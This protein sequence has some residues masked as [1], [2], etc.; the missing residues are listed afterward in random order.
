MG[1]ETFKSPKA[2]K[3]Q[4]RSVVGFLKKSITK[5]FGKTADDKELDAISAFV[6]NAMGKD[7]KE[8]VFQMSAILEA[9]TKGGIIV[10]D[11]FNTSQAHVM[12]LFNA[13]LD[14][15]R[16]IEVTGLGKV[17]AHP[18]FLAIGT[19]NK[20]YQ[21]TFDSN[22]ATV[23]R[24]EPLIFPPLESISKLLE[25]KIPELGYETINI[26]NKLYAG[27]KKGVE[28]GTLGQ[29]ALSTRGFI[30]AAKA[31]S[32]GMSIKRALINSVANRAGDLDDRE[33]IKNMIDLEIGQ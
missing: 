15:R 2:D 13:L 27:I 18:N 29:D 28:S 10:L 33:A 9:F 32:R 5:F 20:G 25:I 23:D 3:E 30:S 19:Q 22:E 1:G 26:C 12:P 17:E 7:D 4:E 16:R 31:M 11:E 14:E 8:L 6:K 24:F 21:G